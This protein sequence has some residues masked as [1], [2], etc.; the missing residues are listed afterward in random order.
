MWQQTSDN[1]YTLGFA[2]LTRM[3]KFPFLIAFVKEFHCKVLPKKKKLQGKVCTPLSCSHSSFSYQA[4]PSSSPAWQR[5]QLKDLSEL[6][7]ATAKLKILCWYSVKLNRGF[8]ALRML[9]TPYNSGNLIYWECWLQASAVLVVDK[10]SWTNLW[11]KLGNCTMSCRGQ[12]TGQ[13]DIF[14]LTA[15]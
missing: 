2:F 6:R 14:N 7:F 4:T 10:A 13:V 5:I 9:M 8:W 1:Q 3:F 11:L 15:S 12:V